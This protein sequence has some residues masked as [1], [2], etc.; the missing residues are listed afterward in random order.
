MT[1]Q[2]QTWPDTGELTRQ[3]IIRLW[4]DTANAG[5]SIDHTYDIGI[6]RWAKIEPVAP[7]AFWNGEQID[8]KPTHKIYVR[9]ASGSRPEDINQQ[10]V[11]DWPL[12]NQ[13]F[14]I[15]RALNM[16]DAQRYTLLE[17]KLLGPIA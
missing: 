5:F 7:M 4:T 2:R 16:M 9:Y 8:E 6:T 13:R 3:V 1:A 11:V 12:M 17:C 10:H 15:L 14:R